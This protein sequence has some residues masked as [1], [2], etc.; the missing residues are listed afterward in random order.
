MNINPKSISDTRIQLHWASQ[1]L[2]SAA[3][4]MLE[5]ADDDSH[6]NLGWDS[7]TSRLVG[8]AESAIGVNGFELH[9]AQDSMSLNGKTLEA[10]KD[11]LSK[12]LG[13][14]LKFRE[15]EMP[16]HQVAS[17]AEFS[18]NF[19]HLESVSE[20]LTFAQH[21]LESHGTLRVWPHHFDLGFW[22]ATEAEGRS[23]GGGFSLGD[24][25]YDQPYFY[26]NPY[27][28]ERP[29]K[30]PSLPV[31]HWSEYWLGA[32]LTADEMN[33]ENGEHAESTKSY[34]DAALQACRD[35]TGEES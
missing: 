30:L 27:G 33:L 29:D 23:I 20:W 13:K 28:I 35:L 19:G 21:S 24:N 18:V 7:E 15:Y 17:G 12:L 25:H 9:Q 2:S 6:S 8:R 3:D 22:K 32:V 31:G 4:A 26:M 34:V 14:E 1:L 5:K 10:A 16:T 11:W